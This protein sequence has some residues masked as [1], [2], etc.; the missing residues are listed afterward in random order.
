MLLLEIFSFALAS[1]FGGWLLSLVVSG[2]RTGRIRHTNTAFTYS[3]RH[4]PVKFCFVALVFLLFSGI[5]LYFAV[6]R[7]LAIWNHVVA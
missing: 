7:A 4:Q 5:F 3:L 1:A 6:L 2:V